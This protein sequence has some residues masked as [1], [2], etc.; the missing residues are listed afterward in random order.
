VIHCAHI[1]S[2]HANAP[3]A[4]QTRELVDRGGVDPSNINSCKLTQGSVVITVT[5]LESIT[6]QQAEDVARAI[7]S[8]NFVYTL[9][10]G[11]TLVVMSAVADTVVTGGTK[12]PTQSTPAPTPSVGGSGSGSGGG[13]SSKD[14]STVEIALVVA[15]VVLGLVLMFLAVFV[16]TRARRR[17]RASAHPTTDATTDNDNF[18]I[19][20]PLSTEYQYS[21]NDRKPGHSSVPMD[22]VSSR[23]QRPVDMI[24]TTTAAA[25][26]NNRPIII[27]PRWENNTPGSRVT[28]D[29][30]DWDDGDAY[31]V[32]NPWYLRHPR[33]LS[34][35]V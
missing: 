9:P 34:S 17:P 19:I 28:F 20:A 18:M 12:S 33:P 25:D 27:T 7:R 11:D 26:Y 10:N 30:P 22:R 5:F 13:G 24:T 4:F 8:G 14:L 32:A 2:L 15:A 6:G 1:S 21:N 3:F 29:G 16:A 35:D 23:D 31:Y